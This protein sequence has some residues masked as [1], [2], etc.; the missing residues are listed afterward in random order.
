M[1]LSTHFLAFT[2]GILLAGCAT[3]PLVLNAGHPASTNAPEAATPPARSTLRADANT[4]R[5]GELLAMRD[6]QATAAE[7]ET[8][9]GQPNPPT[10]APDPMKGMDMKGT[11]GT[12]MKG[13]KHDN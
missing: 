4:A 2:A 13:M 11:K 12:D 8:P 6:R 9:A 7:A 1:D 3:H 5:T 10:T